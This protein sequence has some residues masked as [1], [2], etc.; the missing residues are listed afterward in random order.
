MS[1]AGAYHKIHLP[2]RLVIDAGVRK[3]A[4]GRFEQSTTPVLDDFRDSRASRSSADASKLLADALVLDAAQSNAV[5]DY[6][7]EHLHL[8]MRRATHIKSHFAE[9][10]D[11]RGLPAYI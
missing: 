3:L 5:Y 4:G 9:A 2:W 11:G 7:L 1:A 10:R 6:L 8:D